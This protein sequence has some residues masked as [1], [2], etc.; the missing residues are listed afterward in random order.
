MAKY[1]VEVAD[2]I[3]ARVSTVAKRLLTEVASGH[4]INLRQRLARGEGLDDQPMAPLTR[5]YAKRKGSET[6]D[7]LLTGRMLGSLRVDVDQRK[8]IAKIG[9]SDGG[10]LQKARG[11]QARTPWF[12]FSPKDRAALNKLIQAFMKG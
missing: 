2:G 5:A 4:L 7:L 1:G 6:R 9:F 10:S 3:Q 8:L 12:G 11:N